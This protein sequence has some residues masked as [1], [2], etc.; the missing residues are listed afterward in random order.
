MLRF[1]LCGISAKNYA[2]IISIH[3]M[4]RFN[5]DKKQ[6][7]KRKKIFQYILC[8]GSTHQLEFVFASDTKFQYILCYGS[9][10]LDPEV[11]SGVSRFQYIL[12]YGSTKILS[13]KNWENNNFNTSYVTVQQFLSSFFYSI[14]NI[15]IHLMLRFNCIIGVYISFSLFISI[16]L[17]LR[18]NN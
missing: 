17:M 4:L 9:T 13:R 2:W 12:C 15:S 16:H 7:Q 8:Y 14:S 6:T 5:Q 18:F 1:N 11:I 3:L 10:I